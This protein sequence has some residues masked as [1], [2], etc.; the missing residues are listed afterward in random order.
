[1][2]ES[3][4]KKVLTKEQELLNGLAETARKFVHDLAGEDDQ[5]AVLGNHWVAYFEGWRAVNAGLIKL[6]DGPRN[7][8]LKNE[9]ALLKKFHDALNGD[10][11]PVAGFY[12]DKVFKPDIDDAEDLL[13]GQ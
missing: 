1:M 4:P 10:S 5:V 7:Q 11:S 13:A 9:I 6:E 2:A 3:N 12:R 8:A